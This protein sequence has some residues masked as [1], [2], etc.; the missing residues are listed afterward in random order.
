MIEET[1]VVELLE[2]KG[3][4]VKTS[5]VSGCNSCKQNESCSTS[6]LS[7]YFGS[8]SIQMFLKTDELLEVG[9]TV[10]VGLDEGVF[11]R[12]T[13]L[14][15]FLPLCMLIVA[16]LI[17]QVISESLL[18]SGELLTIASGIAGFIVSFYGLKYFIKHRIKPEYLNPVLLH[19]I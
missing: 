15:Y 5:K 19:K 3:V 2:E 11:L 9:D 12:L 8:K 17:G 6:L 4:R 13:M 10:K 16:A 1:A 7:K 18:I 14:I